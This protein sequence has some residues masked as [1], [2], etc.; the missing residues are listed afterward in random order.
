MVGQIL[1]CLGIAGVD[2]EGGYKG[3]QNFLFVKGRNR[4]KK[5]TC[6]AAPLRGQSV[7]QGLGDHQMSDLIGVDRFWT[8]GV[9]VAVL[10]LPLENVLQA[11]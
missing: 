8:E 3:T 6:T 5:G 2:Q 1:S 11:H 7:H 4:K 10:E 9:G